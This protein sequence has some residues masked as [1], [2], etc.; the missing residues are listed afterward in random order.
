MDYKLAEKVQG[1]GLQVKEAKVYLALLELGRGNVSEISKAA[2]INRTTGY[3][4]LERL[5]FYGLA[6]RTLLGKKKTVYAAE[7]PVRL[8]QYLEKSKTQAERN[9]SEVGS[10]LPELQLIYRTESKPVIRF[11]EGREGIEN[12][13]NHTLNAKSEIYS[14]L[15]L[16][17]YLP[18]FD[19]FGKEHVKNRVERDVREKVLVV[20]NKEGEYFYDSTYGGKKVYQQNTEYRWLDSKFTGIP[21]T[22]I[23]I[24]DDIVMGVLVKP[25]E[26]AAFE[27]QNESFA[28]SLK[29]M[30]E[31]VW[32]QA[33]P[34]K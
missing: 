6:S 9:L 23:N 15:D 27:V 18:E 16:S 25:N 4:I 11:F 20:K 5:S 30:F 8:K 28:N 31:I 21:A 13:Y 33:S 1:L 14:V 2:Q 26:N 32:K 10:L 19:Q 29:M 34:A 17:Q 3:D 7:P 22:E 12:I 24:Y